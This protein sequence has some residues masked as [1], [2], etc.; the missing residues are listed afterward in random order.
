M[1]K[2]WR[3]KGFF[4]IWNHHKCLSKVFSL[5]L[6]SYVMG[7]R[8]W[9][10]G[11]MIITPPPS[12]LRMLIF[13]QCMLLTPYYIIMRCLCLG[14][15]CYSPCSTLEMFMFGWCMS[16]TPQHT[17]DVYF[18]VM[19]VGPAHYEMLIFRW[20]LLLTPQYTVTICLCLRH[21]CYSLT[22]TL[23]DVNI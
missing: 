23:W 19:Y 20:Y 10:Y 12:T 15:V 2:L 18:C 5:H 6:N 11:H 13:R 4:S 21:L 3:P 1:F 7:L 16:I 8:P 9:V 17:Q 14:N 22:S